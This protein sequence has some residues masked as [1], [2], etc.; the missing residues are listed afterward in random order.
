[1]TLYVGSSKIKD[2]AAHGVYVASSATNVITNITNKV[3]YAISP[4]NVTIT[5]S[6]T[7]SNGVATN[8]SASN[9][10]L[11]PTTFNP[12]TSTWE[13]VLKFKTP[14]SLSKNTAIIGPGNTTDCKHVSFGISSSAK[15][16][17]YIS[18]NGTSW[19]L[20]SNK[21]G[22]YTVQPSTVYWGKLQFTG[23]QYIFSYSLDGVNWV[24]DNTLNS[25]TPIYNGQSVPDMVG[26]AGTV[27]SSTTWQ[28]VNTVYLTDCYYKI[29]STV[30]WQGGAGT[31]TLKTGSKVYYPA[32][33][34][35][36]CSVYG[37]PTISN[38]VV[39]NFSSSN[40]LTLPSA[41]NPSGSTWEMVFKI[42][43]PT[44]FASYNAVCGVMGTYSF[45]L[46]FT[47]NKLGLYLS[48]NGTSW[49]LASNITS[50]NTFSVATIYYLKV[51]YTGSQYVVAYK[52]ASGEYVDCITVSSSTAILN[53]SAYQFGLGTN[54]GNTTW[55]TDGNIDLRE[56]YVKV[57]GA[58][59]WQGQTG[60]GSK[61]FEE[62][63]VP[64]DITSTQ[65]G[66]T[67][68]SLFL[69][70]PATKNWISYGAPSTVSYGTTIPTT[71][72]HWNSATN[73]V[74]YYENGALIRS[75]LSLPFAMATRTSGY[76]SAINQVFNS[77]GY[78][79]GVAFVLP[80][81][82]GLIP[83]GLEDNG[84]YKVITYTTS[85][86][87][88]LAVSGTG[89]KE[90]LVK[91]NGDVNQVTGGSVVGSDG[92]LYDKNTSAT[93]LG[94]V[95]TFASTT[96]STA[97]TI[98]SIT[99]NGVSSS[100]MFLEI[101]EIYNGS[102]LVYQYQPYAANTVLANIT[103]ASQTLSLKKGVYDLCITGGGGSYASG[104]YA[105]GSLVVGTR[106][107][108][109]SGATFEG[110]F[111]LPSDSTVVVTAGNYG[112]NSTLSVNGTVML[113]AYAGVHA[114]ANGSGGA[115]GTAP[116]INS[117]LE[118]LTTRKSTAGNKGASWSVGN[119]AKGG[120]TTSTYKW[121]EGG[122]IHT[123]GAVMAGGVR[124]TYLRVNK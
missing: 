21:M 93:R 31:F 1:M 9:Y 36:N 113:T 111:Y 94:S 57:N 39:S 48:S 106:T 75:G 87:G 33:Y 54:R 2:T 59:V 8:F 58:T 30:I 34:D 71:G 28:P 37:S 110:T 25:S 74:S 23:S 123:S 69:D 100:Q 63:T 99:L 19:N 42:K 79:G 115:G 43:T 44:A 78:F 85:K 14:A 3:N 73:V 98:P 49:N 104:I 80:G 56:S 62:Y 82:T 38:G 77:G 5:G 17:L 35:I 122:T 47:G 20:A 18:S 27:L 88:I 6:P 90:L 97:G 4:L 65:M 103:N 76:P 91:S 86:V 40:Y 89:Y 70:L 64:S 96:I 84:T 22:S 50:S 112:A 83:N 119:T 45:T 32:G 109:G 52:T 117:S 105:K 121:G 55:L 95:F 13:K 7:I 66:T 81:V 102:S 108:G 26:N 53:P 15:F 68:G 61:V 67:T 124:L 11:L 12:S 92:Y 10:L 24:V 118:V 46:Q 72:V 101:K 116:A 107:G 51:T 60:S 29:G 120:D 16:N 114:T 41:F